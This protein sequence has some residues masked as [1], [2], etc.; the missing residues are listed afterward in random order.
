MNVNSQN[1]SSNRKPKNF[2]NPERF[3]EGWYWV[4]PSHNLRVGEV[5]PVTILGRKL[6]IYRGKDKR[7]VTLDAY[8][9]HMGAHLAGG[10]VEGNELRCFFHHW[11]FDSEGICVD[12]PCLNEPLPIKLKTWPTA[13]KY[14]MI[15]VWTGEIPQQPI[16][17]I[18]EW[19]EKDC[20]ITFG[21]RLLLKCHPNVVMINAIDAQH[22]NTVHKLSSEVVFEKQ[23]LEQ[24]AI[25]FRNSTRGKNQSFFIKIIHPFYKNTV[26]YTI[27]YWYGSTAILTINSDYL[28]LNIMFPLRL[29]KGGK[30]ESQTLLMNKKR[31]GI[32]GWLYNQFV[33]LLT[34]IVGQYFFVGDSKIFQ[35]IRFDLKT[36]IKADQSIMQLIT[37][38]ERQKPLMWGTWQEV[39]SQQAES[40]PKRERWQ[41]NMV[42]D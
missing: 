30:S 8:C 23:E 22:F 5:K 12:I 26:T 19:E 1:F 2:N 32:L 42:N 27:C 39:R 9:P 7:A 29:I 10:K 13:E 36:P 6:V 3:I 18:P 14:G 33:L 31:K 38:V 37:H 20:D 40:K 17:F 11:K 28:H 35:T 4:I 25:V 15:W 41:D 34:K 21:P 16:P 24:N